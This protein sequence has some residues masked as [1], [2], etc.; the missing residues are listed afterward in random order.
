MADNY[1][2]RSALNGFNRCDVLTYIDSLLQKMTAENAAVSELEKKLADAE[3]KIDELQKQLESSAEEKNSKCTDCS[4]EK[5]LEARLGAAMLDAKRFSEILVK[6]ANDRASGLFSQAADSA[7]ATA[8]KS[9]EIAEK[10]KEVKKELDTAV[11]SLIEN[12]VTVTASLEG[13][14]D[15]VKNESKNFNFLTEFSS[16]ADKCASDEK[17]E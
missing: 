7:S 11:D 16:A 4:I 8:V 12:M 9:G 5:V 17:S 1:C 3:C 14:K 6:E 10:I 2:F 15:S 13:F